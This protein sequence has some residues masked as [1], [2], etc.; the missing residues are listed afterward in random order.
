MSTGSSVAAGSALA[1]EGPAYQLL[2]LGGG[3]GATQAFLDAADG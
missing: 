2:C 3:M 1:S